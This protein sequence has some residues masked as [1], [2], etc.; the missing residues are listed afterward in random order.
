MARLATAALC[1]AAAVITANSQTQEVSL[2]EIDNDIAVL[3]DS[4]ASNA[5]KHEFDAQNVELRTLKL[6][7]KGKIVD[8][9]A[10][11]TKAQ[12][13]KGAELRAQLDDIE[14][15]AAAQLAAATAEVATLSTELADEIPGKIAELQ[16]WVHDKLDHY[17][18]KFDFPNATQD[19]KYTKN[20]NLVMIARSPE[21]TE[22]GHKRRMFYKVEF[23]PNAPG[24]FECDRRE[25]F[26]A[27]RQLSEDLEEH[28]G[29]DRD[30]R[31]VCDHDHGQ[32]LNA[33]H[34]CGDQSVILRESY[35]SHCGGSGNHRRSQHCI[36]ME[37]DFLAGA[38]F[39]NREHHWNGCWMH[40]HEGRPNAHEWVNQKHESGRDA[41][42][43]V[44]TSKSSEYW[45]TPPKN[46][47]DPQN[48]KKCYTEGYTK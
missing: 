28:D 16:S 31:P 46:W 29:I 30:L 21:N 36:G 38:V 44:C 18:K 3:E 20:Y 15:S 41:M 8:A 17:K 5:V 32:G 2:F 22:N 7:L 9:L 19:L 10:E 34:Y 42:T 6:D 4:K 11:V 25:L 23:N 47:C 27:C 37:D 24:Y 1:L 13:T 39:Y 40:R 35:L 43:T 45:Q 26:A 33:N 14:T 12:I 48:D